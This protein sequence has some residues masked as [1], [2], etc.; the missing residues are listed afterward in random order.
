MKCN[1][2]LAPNYLLVRVFIMNR[3]AVFIDGFNLYH[4]LQEKAE[5]RKLKWL[6]L[7]KFSKCFLNPKDQLDKV[8]YF[9][10]FAT[11]DPEKVKKH[12]IYV[13]ALKFV[14]VDVVLGAFRYVDKKCMLCN[15]IYQTFEE[16]RTD[17]NIAIK[18]FQTAIEDLWDTALIISGDSDL[19]PAIEAVKKS[20]PSKQ[21]GIVIPIGRR[22]EELK[23][24]ADFHKK[25]KLKHLTT[26]QF[27]DKIDL[28]DGVILKR[29]DSWR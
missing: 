25:V 22:A 11:W 23:L 15:R 18:L 2:S 17:V 20:F 14:G 28:G 8:Y 26:C 10:A 19:I 21:I 6:N 13:K 16:K 5:T 3:T 29:P 1:I 24:V 12:Q 27:D 7:N 4:A 9:T